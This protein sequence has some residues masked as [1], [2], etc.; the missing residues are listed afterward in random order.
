MDVAR[1]LVR[2]GRY[3]ISRIATVL[4]VSR[5]NLYEHPRPRPK[6]Y[7]RRD[8]G[9]VRGEILN[10]LKARET[11]GYKRT[12]G[13]LN[14]ERRKSGLKPYNKKRIYRVMDMNKLLVPKR[15][16]KTER[17]HTGKVMTIMSNLRWCSD[18][19]QINC[20]SG[21]K[22]F[23]AF[24]LDCHDR[25]SMAHVAYARPLTH[26]DII[27]L[28]D[29]T[30]VSRFG[31]WADKLEIPVQWLSDQG[32][33]YIAYETK[34][35]AREWGLVPITTPSYSP[36]SN[37]MA[38]AFVKTFKRDYVYVSDLWTAES[39][40]RQVPGWFA[41]YNENHPH[42]ALKFMSPLEYRKQALSSEKVYV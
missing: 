10:Q 35:Y 14:R 21:E 27:E 36:E 23:V 7:R 6:R 40:L 22:V 38:E 20:W 5:S 24:S 29:R 41:D 1:E 31:E 15:R 11:Y 2:R 32:P 19:L 37:G 28:I 33:Q 16:L 39:V 3:R 18:I 8:D 25:E 9:E 4:N 17:P 42:S 34:N 12:T 13:I 30:M 26:R